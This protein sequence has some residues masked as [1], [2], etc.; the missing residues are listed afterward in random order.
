MIPNIAAT[1]RRFLTGARGLPL[2]NRESPILLFHMDDGDI[3]DEESFSWLNEAQTQTSIDLLEALFTHLPAQAEIVI[4]CLYTAQKRALKDRLLGRPRVRV[5]TADAYQANQADIVV[6]VTTRSVELNSQTSR[7]LDFVT[8]DRRAT[9]ALSRAR[10][11]LIII[12]NLQTLSY[13]QVWRKFLTVALEKTFAVNPEE[14]LSSINLRVPL[15]PISVPL[16]PRLPIN[17]ITS[18]SR[19][20]NTLETPD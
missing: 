19:G 11:G 4:L 6:L 8:D 12:G 17:S 13:G 15:A 3:R 20:W 2:P 16:G 14:Y 18:H 9:V 1:E 7:I 10:H 5:V